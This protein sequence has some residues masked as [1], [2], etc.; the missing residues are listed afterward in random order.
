MYKYN[1]TIR[2]GAEALIDGIENIEMFLGD[3]DHWN[4]HDSSIRSFHWD[5]ETGEFTVTVEPIGYGCF[6][7]EIDKDL[8]PLLDFHFEDCVEIKMDVEVIGAYINDIKISRDRD[9]LECCF[10][11]IC[12]GVACRRLRVDKPRFVPAE[13][14]D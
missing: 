7:G 5:N 13:D 4:F 11:G 10:N 1:R 6:K 12:V 3:E 2:D 8:Q 9:Y 14:E